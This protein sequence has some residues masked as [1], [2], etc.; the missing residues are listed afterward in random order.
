M[1]AP[2]AIA[3]DRLYRFL[4]GDING[5]GKTDLLFLINS[6]LGQNITL[7]SFLSKGDGTF[8]ATSIYSDFPGWDENSREGEYRNRWM[9]GDANGDGRTDIM[10]V[11]HQN[12]CS[13][14]SASAC[15][16]DPAAT[17]PP[18]CEHAMFGVGL[19]NGDGTFT[20]RFQDT[21]WAFD[22]LNQHGWYTGEVN[23]DGKTDFMQILEGQSH[24]HFRVAISRGDGTFDLKP[25]QGTTTFFKQQVYVPQSNPYNWY[26]IGNDYTQVGDFN[27]DGLTDFAFF[28]PYFDSWTNSSRMAINVAFNDDGNGTF[29]VTEY[30]TTN[31]HSWQQN[32]NSTVSLWYHPNRWLIGDVNGDGADDIIIASP[33]DEHYTIDR[34]ISDKK[35]GFTE[36]PKFNTFWPLRH[37]CNYVEITFWPDCDTETKFSVGVG[38]INGDGK[39][40]VLYTGQ[41]I[42]ANDDDK[43]LF[44]ADLSPNVGDD[45]QNW[46]PADVDG[47]GR[48]DLVYM[49]F[50]NYGYDVHVL[51][52]NA[53]GTY[54]RLAEQSVGTSNADNADSGS[55]VLMDTTAPTGSSADGK[56]DLV[57][58]DHKDAFPNTH[59]QIVTVA[60]EGG[61]WTIRGNQYFTLTP[62]SEFPIGYIARRWLPADINGDGKT[63]LV[64]V[65]HAGGQAYIQ[66]IMSNGDGTWTWIPTTAA[67]Q[68]LLPG[69]ER[70]WRALDINADGK[71]DLVLVTTENGQTVVR[72]LRSNFGPGKTD[73]TPLTSSIATPTSVSLNFPDTRNWKPMEVNGD[74][75][76]D[77]VYI[78][79]TDVN[80]PGLR[81]FL[82]HTLLSKGNGEW[83]YSD[84]GG[85]FYAD[86]PISHRADAH[87]FR[88]MDLN[89]DGKTDLARVVSYRSGPSYQ[90]LGTRLTAVHRIMNRVSGGW[91]GNTQTGLS[92]GFS[93]TPAWRPMDSNVDTKPDLVYVSPVIYTLHLAAPSEFLSEIQN[94]T[95]GTTTIAYATSAGNHAYMPNGSLRTIVASVRK[96][97]AVW[98]RG[99]IAESYTFD[100]AL[101]SDKERTFVG[102]AKIGVTEGASHSETTFE[103]SDACLSRPKVV[104]VKDKFGALIQQRTNAFVSTGTA[105]PF[106]CM[107]E[108]VIE[109]ECEGVLPCGRTTSVTFEHDSY[110]NVSRTYVW[111]LGNTNTDDRM[112]EV[113]SLR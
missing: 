111:G 33:R 103:Q 37:S 88:P 85:P 100:G 73:Y 94:G 3:A 86:Y 36:V 50:N 60:S 21:N 82:V 48:T 9:T 101:W 62:G 67:F 19:S 69:D 58:I 16:C 7:V 95:M 77:L 10:V 1:M 49:R 17:P 29:Y 108:K 45:Q 55:W 105:A 15:G 96:W 46:R 28:T 99:W 35:G 42:D 25:L 41:Y 20:I 59:L 61:T 12:F 90:G 64:H 11:R 43:V 22:R 32:Y 31:I 92:F 106:I 98:L 84:G 63:D 39:A 107:V 79:R 83:E 68:G 72:S 47:D 2:T 65:H 23:G 40:D 91:A 44:R 71:S 52:K 102:F 113:R 93:D 66:T 87:A 97:D 5:D 110:G 18:Q 51:M 56:A 81:Y 76:S 14:A 80:S 78:E 54:S 24:A 53:D 27:G 4:V 74:G 75:A 109:A 38:D 30:K 112:I 57:Q 6:G 104:S 26:A 70:N 8:D 34:L 13:S 89:G